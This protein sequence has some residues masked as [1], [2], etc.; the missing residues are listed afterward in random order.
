MALAFEQARRNLL[1]FSEN[2]KRLRVYILHRGR[3]VAAAGSELFIADTADEAR[4][5]AKDKHPGEMPHGR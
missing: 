5:L 3:Y 1:W 2:A 4:R